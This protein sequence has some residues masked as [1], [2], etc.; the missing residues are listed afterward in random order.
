[1]RRELIVTIISLAVTASV[2]NA[3]E[4]AAPATAIRLR[5][6]L[7]SKE[8]FIRHEN[9]RPTASGFVTYIHPTKPILMHCFGRE[10]Y[11]DGY[12]D[13]AVSLSRDNG[14]TWSKPEVRWKSRIVP[15]G[16]MRYA[17]PAAFFDAERGKLIVLIDH[18]LYPKD[19]LNVDT[20]YGLELNVFD[21]RREKWTEQ[22][23]LRFPG[24]RVP[25]MSF[26]FPIK[27]ASGRLLFPGMRKTIDAAGRAV[28]FKTTWAPVDEV[29]TVLGEYGA[30][31]ELTW[32]LGQP[33]NIAPELSS[34]GLDENALIELRDGHIAAICRGDNSAFSDKP[35]YKWLSF[36]SNDGETWSAP[37]PLPASVGDP[38]ESGAN[39]SA[40][41][42]SLKN[43]RLY[44]MGN[45]ALRGERPKGNWPRSPLVIVEVQEE[46]FA[47]KRD[48]IFV[49][50][51]RGYNDS[52]RV[53]M[54]NF[55]FY[56]DRETGDVVIFLTRYGEHSEKQWMLA[57]YY[58]YRVEM[59]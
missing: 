47:L 20:E 24:E 58:R 48:T 5:P 18:T 22:R 51:E 7:L 3:G 53:Q 45:L 38:V 23:E 35:G 31:G 16:K 6:K 27:T 37:V 36:S 10:D 42:R 33:L 57:D 1:M 46:P 21:T 50:D 9:G 59:P 17:E 34:R 8:I 41:F 32:R 15:E 49:V 44:W 40:L 4:V 14:K 56:Q 19:K 39:G 25:A 26:T 13:Y 12:D 55:R 28:H 30:R 2:L 29:V 54:S 43:R 52:P 11:S